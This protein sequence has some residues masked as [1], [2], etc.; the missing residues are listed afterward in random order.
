MLLETLVIFA[1]VNGT[2]CTETS[3]QYYNT[4]PEI[5]E[6]VKANEEKVKEFIGP[7]MLA[8]FSPIAVAATGGTSTFRLSKNFNLQLS[9][10]SQKLTYGFDF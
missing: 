6:M 5:K 2:G 1:C 8:V 3:S 10:N 4:H 7:T 9:V